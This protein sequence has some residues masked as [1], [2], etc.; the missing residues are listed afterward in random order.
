MRSTVTP[1][2][3]SASSMATSD[4][5]S[6]VALAPGATRT[7]LSAAHTD[8]IRMRRASVSSRMR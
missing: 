2:G 8:A 7:A 1:A 6:R 3:A 5:W 4:E